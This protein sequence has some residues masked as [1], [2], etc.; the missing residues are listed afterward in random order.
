MK[1]QV[2]WLALIA[3][4][5]M[6]INDGTTLMAGENNTVKVLSVKDIQ[7][8][9]GFA[10]LLD[11]SKSLK[12]GQLPIN[13]KSYQPLPLPKSKPSP[14]SSKARVVNQLI[15]YDLV[16][17]S[18]TIYQFSKSELKTL[19]KKSWKGNPGQLLK[20]LKTTKG[21]VREQLKEMTEPLEKIDHP[22]QYAEI[23]ANVKL[24]MV[25]GDR[26]R[27]TCSGTL[28]DPKLVITAGHCVHEGPGGDFYD[29]V[30]VIPAY[31]AGEAPLGYAVGYRLS[32]TPG[33]AESADF[34][35]DI[36]LVELE[37][38]IGAENGW[39][40][41]KVDKVEDCSAYTK[42]TEGSI[43]IN[44]GYP[45]DT[46]YDGEYLYARRGTFDCC[47]E[48]CCSQDNL[49]GRN[50]VGINNL[51]YRGQS[52]SSAALFYKDKDLAEVPTV[53][54][55]LSNGTNEVDELK[56]T[57]FIVLESSDNEGSGKDSLALLIGGVIERNTPTSVDLIPR[58]VTVSSTAI[59]AGNPLPSLN[60][61]VHNYSSVS[62]EG[63]VEYE[64]F[65]FDGIQTI[66]VIGK[67][68]FTDKFSPK[69]SVSVTLSAGLPTIPSDTPAGKSYLGV[70]LNI[71]DH[72][73]DNNVTDFQSLAMIEV[74]GKDGKP[75]T[76][77]VPIWRRDF[78]GFEG[79]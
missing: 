14:S 11:K 3:T 28:V 12:H 24:F 41:L 8:T 54:A 63:T 18:K 55:I 67:G 27:A 43:F 19:A 2:Q 48:E 42:P 26:I 69:G 17:G 56:F 40:G 73:G 20:S 13:P 44:A 39:Y 31:E 38:P 34:N 10:K 46:P 51:S 74:I 75:T 58:K 4:A 77:E 49:C 5:G 61:L 79:K 16:A 72:N 64:V 53:M 9:P 36:G 57:N 68:Q 7:Q 59:T 33:W 45:G 52:G 22:A 66:T 65:L 37:E 30:V 23:V 71:A 25:K 35:Y 1:T 47:F 70:K 32:T 78:P 60:F 21:R 50:Q 15:A 76:N 29:A 6:L 62:W